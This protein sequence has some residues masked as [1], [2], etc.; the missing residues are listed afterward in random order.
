MLEM[1]INVQ[2]RSVILKKFTKCACI[3]V[4]KKTT[5][6]LQEMEILQITARM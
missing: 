1:K 4:H 3:F 2:L 6:Y 5:D